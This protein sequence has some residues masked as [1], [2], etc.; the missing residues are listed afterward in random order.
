[1]A[2]SGLRMSEV[3]AEDSTWTKEERCNRMLEITRNM[4]KTKSLQGKQCTHNSIMRNVRITN[5]TVEK[6][7]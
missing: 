5:V 4:E 1:M 7:Y 6:Q 2:E 3:G